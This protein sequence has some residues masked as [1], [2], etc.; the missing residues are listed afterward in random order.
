VWALEQ[1][2]PERPPPLLA[3]TPAALLA[4]LAGAALGAAALVA[5]GWLPGAALAVAGVAAGHGA[6]LATALAWALGGRTLP[7]VGLVALLALAALAA[8]SHPLGLLAY[9][10]PPLVV[11]RLAA[12]GRLAALGLGGGVPLRGVAAGAALGALLGGHLLVSASLTLGVAVGARPA[13]ELLGALA[14]DAGANVLAAECFFRGAL[15]A[16]AQRRWPAAGAAALSTGAYVLRYLVDPLLPK[17]VELV[18]GAAFYLTL[19]GA[20]NCWLLRR[21]GSLLPGLASALVFFAA[22][23]LCDAP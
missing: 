15:F 11:A 21:S 4:A 16:R 7:G 20:A 1:P 6:L 23:R 9:A 2:C 5:G 13:G 17:S 10:G 14:Y 3:D 18:V 19:L 12:R 8:R 22:W